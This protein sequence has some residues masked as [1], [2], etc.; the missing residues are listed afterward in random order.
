[1]ATLL[2]E[3]RLCATLKSSFALLSLSLSLSLS[4][5]SFTPNHGRRNNKKKNLSVFPKSASALS[6]GVASEPVGS[7]RIES[8]PCPKS[9]SLKSLSL[10]SLFM[11]PQILNPTRIR[12]AESVLQLFE[13][14]AVACSQFSC[15]TLFNTHA[16][17]RVEHQ[18]SPLN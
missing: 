16:L 3:K 18:L 13:E 6:S 2:W 10:K 11:L 17:P 1:M 14:V 8:V 9:A 12:L 7:H 4:N 5:S 15:S